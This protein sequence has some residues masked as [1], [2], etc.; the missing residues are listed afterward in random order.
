MSN[1]TSSLPLSQL[2]PPPQSPSRDDRV[3]MPCP[4][5]GQPF[6]PVGRQRVCS[7]ACRQAV[8]R[9]RHQPSAVAAVAAPPM[10]RSR[11][12]GTIYECPTC[13]TR[14][15]GSQRCPN[16]QVFCRRIGP[17]GLCPH[18]EEPVAVADLVAG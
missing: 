6:A 16:C 13:E 7:A 9:R 17:G 11:R 1:P 2:P 5:C 14:Y 18:C 10:A 15:L 3:T 12:D 8:Y 4:V